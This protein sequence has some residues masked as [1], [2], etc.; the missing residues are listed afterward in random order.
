MRV[1]TG[2][3]SVLFIVSGCAGR[4]ANPVADYRIGDETRSCASLKAEVS[5]INADIARLVSD[6]DKTGKN[7][8]L[9]VAGLFLIVP[10]FFMDL[11]DAERTEAEA[12]RRRHNRLTQIAAD[13]RCSQQYAVQSYPPQGYVPTIAPLPVSPPQPSAL[14]VWLKAEIIPT[15]DPA[16]YRKDKCG[17]WMQFNLLGQK[18]DYGWAIDRIVPVANG[19]GDTLANLQPL[20]WNNKERRNRSYPWKC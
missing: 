17:N 3:L 1:L 20:W 11:S 19:G 7:V 10:W 9:G 8:A 2:Y 5:Q 14:T 12:Y 6:T 16:L 18:G 15:H 4:T 13:K